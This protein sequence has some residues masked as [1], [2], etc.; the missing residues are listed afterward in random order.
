MLH[1]YWPKHLIGTDHVERDGFNMGV[2]LMA[3]GMGE[4]TNKTMD[5][6]RFR[7]EVLARLHDEEFYREVDLELWKGLTINSSNSPRRTWLSRKKDGFVRGKTYHAQ[8]SDRDKTKKQAE[9]AFKLHVAQAEMVAI[10]EAA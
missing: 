5:E 1:C 4:I 2:F 7:G 8:P 3:T 6:L 9:A 10:G